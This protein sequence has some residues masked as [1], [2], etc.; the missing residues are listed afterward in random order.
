[1]MVIIALPIGLLFTALVVVWFGMMSGADRSL[2]FSKPEPFAYGETTRYYRAVVPKHIDANTK[3]IIGLSG[4]GGNGRRFAYYSSLHNVAVNDIVVYP[5]PLPP[6]KKG[7]K[8]GWNAGYCCGSGWVNGTDD[9]GFLSSLGQTL[10]RQYGVSQDKLFAVGFSN[11]AFMAQRLA[12]ERPDVFSAV[13][14]VSGSIGTKAKQLMPT[15]PIAILLMH[16]TADTI[17]PFNGGVGSSDPDFDWT[18][19]EHTRRTWE[20]ANGDSQP[21]EVH[22]YEGLGHAWKGWRLFQ[23]WRKRPEASRQIMSFFESVSQ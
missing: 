4:F 14:A 21:V 5:E 9:V 16:G 18:T 3:L 19:F 10:A 8:T 12:A 6:T 15:K 2:F 13:A 11:G 17:V 22:V 20:D 1:M 7:Q 23:P